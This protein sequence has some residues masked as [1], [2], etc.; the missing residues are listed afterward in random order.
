VRGIHVLLRQQSSDQSMKGELMSFDKSAVKRLAELKD[1]ELV[2][3][4]INA[5]WVLMSE[6]ILGE[7]GYKTHVYYLGHESLNPER[8]KS[9]E[10]LEAKE[11]ATDASDDLDILF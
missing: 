3:K 5:G 11:T 7:D 10:V 1:P 6:G 9:D 4:Y 2:E 8:P